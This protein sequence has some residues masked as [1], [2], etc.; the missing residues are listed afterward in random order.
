LQQAIQQGHVPPTAAPQRRARRSPWPPPSRWLAAMRWRPPRRTSRA[1]RRP[2]EPARPRR[3]DA[4]WARTGTIGQRAPTPRQRTGACRDGGTSAAGPGVHVGPGD[5]PRRV[6]V[7]AEHHHQ[8]GGPPIGGLPHLRVQSLVAFGFFAAATHRLAPLL[9]TVL[10]AL[11][12]LGIFTLPA[13]AP[14]CCS[15]PSAYRWRRPSSSA[16]PRPC[17]CTACTCCGCIAAAGQRRHDAIA[18]PPCPGLFVNRF[19]HGRSRRRLT[20]GSA[21]SAWTSCQ[22]GPAPQDRGGAQLAFHHQQGADDTD[23]GIGAPKGL[24]GFLGGQKATL[25]GDGLPATPAS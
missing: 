16:S 25:A 21:A 6:A 22:T 20:A 11:L 24:R 14:P 5:R 23:T 3:V 18:G 17:W 10:P 2:D 9:A 15:M 19:G 13:R 7:G 12:I 1:T 4:A 8:R